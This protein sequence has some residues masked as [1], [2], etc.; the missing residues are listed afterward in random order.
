[1]NR[2]AFL[3]P[4][5]IFTDGK[6]YINNLK[7]RVM[8]VRTPPSPGESSPSVYRGSTPKGGEGVLL[9]YLFNCNFEAFAVNRYHY[10]TSRSSDSLVVRVN[11]FVSYYLT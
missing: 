8:N 3:F 2:E 9:S 4:C 10:D 11:N 6:E 7:F 1:M 5:L